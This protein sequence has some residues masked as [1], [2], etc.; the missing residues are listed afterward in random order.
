[1]LCSISMS[2]C[3]NMCLFFTAFT[4]TVTQNKAPYLGYIRNE[5]VITDLPFGS[6]LR[7]YEL[8]RFKSLVKDNLT[9]FRIYTRAADRKSSC[10]P[11]VL[12]PAPQTVSM[13]LMGRRHESGGRR[14][15]TIENWSYG[16][17]SAFFT[18]G[19]KKIC[20][21]C[22]STSKLRQGTNCSTI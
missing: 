9:K 19:R 20:N 15:I 18:D 11:C 7:F 4:A 16:F 1:M 21:E 17:E 5:A 3:Q 10:V 14:V 8:R 22:P 6:G 12:V 2:W 13:F